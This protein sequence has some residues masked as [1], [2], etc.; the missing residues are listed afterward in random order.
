MAESHAIHE[1]HGHTHD[2]HGHDE[3]HVGWK[4][5]V[6]IGVILTVI[7]AVEVAIFYIEALAPFAQA[8]RAPRP[9]PGLD[10]A[11]Y[12]FYAYVREDGF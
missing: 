1:H 10:H 5:Y 9:A 12:R 6:V 3:H 4:K 11:W 2:A 7:T 8:I